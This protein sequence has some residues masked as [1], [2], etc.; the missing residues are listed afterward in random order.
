MT[1]DYGAIVTAL[2]GVLDTWQRVADA[3]NTQGK[4]YSTNH[5][6]KIARGDTKR[7]G[8][9]T[10]RGIC[11]AVESSTDCRI[12]RLYSPVA[13]ARYGGLAIALGL[14]DSIREWKNVHSMTW[15]E[16]HEK[17]DVLMRRENGEGSE[18]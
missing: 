1:A 16:W 6:R 9:R 11:A 12:T 13:R 3:C 14:R 17:A 10:R 7:P 5:Y 18:E 15:D 8:A 2:Y 4:A